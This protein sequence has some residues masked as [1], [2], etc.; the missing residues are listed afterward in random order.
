M[1]VLH[2]Y[3][4]QSLYGHQTKGDNCD[5]LVW[6]PRLKIDKT[7]AFRGTWLLGIVVIS[8]ALPSRCS[9]LRS[10]E[11]WKSDIRSPFQALGSISGFGQKIQMAKK[12]HT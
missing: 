12:A 2:I 6:T 4:N 1:W 5:S 3:C 10:L 8:K 9:C 11:D 7:N